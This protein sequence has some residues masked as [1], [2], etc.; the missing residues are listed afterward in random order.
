M[1]KMHLMEFCGFIRDHAVVV[2]RVVNRD[3]C[4]VVIR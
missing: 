3:Y 2:L 1:Y 4:M